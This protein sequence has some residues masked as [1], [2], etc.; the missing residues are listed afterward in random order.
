MG[1]VYVEEFLYRGRPP[2]DLRPPAWHIVLFENVGESEVD[3][4]PH[5]RSHTL[6]VTQAEAA[7]YP[8]PK[9]I[10]AINSEALKEIERMRVVIG[11]LE[12]KIASLEGNT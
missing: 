12:T 10:D 4:Q 1:A 3:K 2:N 11:Q 7:G 6:N 9:L 8:L 5:Y